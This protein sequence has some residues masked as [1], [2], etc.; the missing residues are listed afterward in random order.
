LLVENRIL[1]VYAIGDACA[2]FGKGGSSKAE[3]H[4]D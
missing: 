3:Q 4:S 2:W 1:G